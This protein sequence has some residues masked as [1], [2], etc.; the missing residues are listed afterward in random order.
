MNKEL[1]LFA[2]VLALMIDYMVNHMVLSFMSYHLT[3]S[4]GMQ[5]IKQSIN[6]FYYYVPHID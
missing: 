2:T 3:S 1:N 6:S 4:W 5:Y